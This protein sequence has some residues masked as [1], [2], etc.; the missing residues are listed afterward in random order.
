MRKDEWGKG[1][2]G[3][4]GGGRRMAEDEENECRKRK[5]KDE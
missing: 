4:E 5:G 2:K 1:R 3:K